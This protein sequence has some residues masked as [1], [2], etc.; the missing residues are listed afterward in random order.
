MGSRFQRPG[1]A[2]AVLM[3]C[4]PSA[5]AGEG[6]GHADPFAPVLLAIAAV[7][8]VAMLGRKLA[9]K[10]GQPAVLGE[11]V[12][13]VLLGNLGWWLGVP[14][15]KLMMQFGDVEP[16]I[17]QMWVDGD[18]IREVA[19]RVFS[20]E[21]MAAGGRAH[22]LVGLLTGADGPRMVS[23]S[24]AL[25]LFSNFGVIL[26]LFMVGLESSVSDMLKVGSRAVMVALVG[27]VAPFVSGYLAAMA[28]LPGSSNATR[29]FLGATLCATSIGITARV[30]K[31]LGTIQSREARLIV[32]AAVIDDVLGLVI[33]AVV[34]G[35]ATSG[36]VHIGEIASLSAISLAFIGVVILLGERMAR[37]AATFCRWLDP[38]NNKLLFPLA[39]AFVTA[40]LANLI[41]LAAIIGA[42]AAGL[43]IKEHVF[44]PDSGHSVEEMVAPLEKLFAPVFFVVMGMQ[45]NLA[46]MADPSTVLTGAALLVVSIAGKLV[47]GMS[48]GRD[49]NRFAVGIG[50]VPRGEVGLIF[51]GIGKSVGVIDESLFS[52][53]VL[54]LMV[55]TMITPPALKWALDRRKT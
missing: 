33:L 50:M 54:V 53:L 23:I 55:T 39:A 32:G 47:S 46:A 44:G 1:L 15:F 12:I 26:L 18:S 45:V 8:A 34:V 21:Q 5:M 14:I 51:A 4:A 3:A 38:A 48:A 40:W 28:L 31:D 6:G 19:G 41:G 25:W 17:R 11:L 29:L 7:I 24:T 9:G 13:G 30:F 37:W 35:I 49:V 2:V 22:E 27:V 10:V 16:L 52:M 43:V 20:P 42:F 36:G